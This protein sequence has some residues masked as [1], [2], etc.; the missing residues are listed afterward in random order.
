[1]SFNK[2][3]WAR[4]APIEKQPRKPG[5]PAP[6]A[7]LGHPKLESPRSAAHSLEGEALLASLASAPPLARTPWSL[8]PQGPLR[9]F[10]EAGETRPRCKPQGTKI[11]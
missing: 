1:M 10:T 2:C 11:P 9:A 4:D 8:A 5:T 3:G 7:A 6:C